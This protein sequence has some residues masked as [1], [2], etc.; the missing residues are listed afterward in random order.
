MAA[1]RYVT[2]TRT[3]IS[4]FNYYR[5]HFA[6]IKVTVSMECMYPQHIVMENILDMLDLLWTSALKLTKKFSTSFNLKQEAFIRRYEDWPEEVGLC[7]EMDLIPILI[8]DELLRLIF[9]PLVEADW[10]VISVMCGCEET[11]SIK[12]DTCEHVFS[13]L[14]GDW[15]WRNDITQ[16]MSKY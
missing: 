5:S 6:F 3:H 2:E 13:H 4:N 15:R 11:C 10:S 14:W 7:R 8:K 9:T 1:T 12:S 16:F